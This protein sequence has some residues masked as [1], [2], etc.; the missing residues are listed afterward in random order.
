MEEKQV[1]LQRKQPTP[2]T[3]YYPYGINGRHQEIKWMGTQGKII[4]ERPVPMEVFI[5]LQESTSALKTGALVVKPTEDEEINYV[6][7][8][9]ENV[10]QAEKAALTKEQVQVIL[11]TGNQNVLKKALAN[12]TK[13]LDETLTKEVKRQVQIIACELGIDSSVK[14]KVLADWLGIDPENADLLFD[15]TI[16]ELHK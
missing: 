12:L 15:K 10:E 7:A 6:K 3:V 11:E 8:N 1:I 2:Y 16:E 4:N 14:R 5:W 9:I 13:D